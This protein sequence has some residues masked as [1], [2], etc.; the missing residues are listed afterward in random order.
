MTIGVVAGVVV[1]VGVA[2]VVEGEV[3]IGDSV[4]VGSD[5][6]LFFGMRT[7]SRTIIMRSEDT[8]TMIRIFNDL[9]KKHK[10]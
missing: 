5:S 3:V 7:A 1:V 10:I 6:S 4:D 2:V 9:H 8:P